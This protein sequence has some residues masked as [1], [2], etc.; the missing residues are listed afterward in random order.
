MAARPTPLRLL[1]LTGIA[2]T[3]A[4]TSACGGVGQAARAADPPSVVTYH[5]NDG[6]SFRHPAAWKEYPF[7]WA[8][9]LHFQPIVYLST[10]TVHDPCSAHGSE[11]SCGFPVRHLEPRGVLVSWQVS[12]IPTSGLR[13]APGETTR[14]GGSYAKRVNGRPGFCRRI[15]ADETVEV[16][17][18]SR[19]EMS[20]PTQF[21]ACL[22][23]P[24]LA[25]NVRRV[26][27]LLASTRLHTS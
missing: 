3:C 13:S 9:E 22:R 21:I 19:D 10:Q 11:T 5:G 20:I 8:G 6:L 18:G 27:A 16:L 26:D 4:F 14:V 7:R 25:Q 12:G 17:I 15:G 2:V 23:G 24:N 1:L